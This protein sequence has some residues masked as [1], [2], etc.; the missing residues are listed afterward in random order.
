[1][2][3]LRPEPLN[4]IFFDED[5]TFARLGSRNFA[6]LSLRLQGDWVQ[7]NQSGGLIEVECFHGNLRLTIAL[8][9]RAGAGGVIQRVWVNCRA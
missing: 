5:P 2:I 8:I 6:R 7:F 4:Q 1:M 3:V 9:E